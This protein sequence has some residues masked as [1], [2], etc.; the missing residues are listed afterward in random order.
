MRRWTPHPDKIENCDVC[1]EM[2]L[3]GVQGTCIICGRDVML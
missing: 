3:D 2:M 1:T